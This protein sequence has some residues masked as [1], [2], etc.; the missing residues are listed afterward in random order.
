MWSGVWKSSTKKIQVIKLVRNGGMLCVLMTTGNGN[1]KSA[2]VADDALEDGLRA[3]PTSAR[4]VVCV[5]RPTTVK[6]YVGRVLS[7]L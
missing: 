2:V 1:G 7:F 5:T 3:P 4:G 6:C